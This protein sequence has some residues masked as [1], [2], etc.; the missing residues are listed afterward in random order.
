MRLGPEPRKPALPV[1]LLEPGLAYKVQRT[2]LPGLPPVRPS[3]HPAWQTEL[4]SEP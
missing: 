1:R 4:R 2:E 3:G